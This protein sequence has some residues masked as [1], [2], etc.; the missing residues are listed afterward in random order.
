M[1]THTEATHL[2]VHVQY[3]YISVS[4]KEPLQSVGASRLP[5]L[6]SGQ[7]ANERLELGARQRVCV[8]FEPHAHHR[9]PVRMP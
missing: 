5:H 6:N 2:L 1:A 9:E 7:I 8:H 3:S 4:R